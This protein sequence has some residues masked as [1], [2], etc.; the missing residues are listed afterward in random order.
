MNVARTV[1]LKFKNGNVVNVDL[2]DVLIER[3]RGT[4]GLEADDQ[5]TDAHVKYY[6]VSSMRNALEKFDAK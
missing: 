3:I 1:E 6:L 2:S 4:L 5:V